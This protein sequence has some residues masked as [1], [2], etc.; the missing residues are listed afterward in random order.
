[1]GGGQRVQPDIHAGQLQAGDRVLDF[2][3]YGVD[4]G[5]E[6]LAML[7]RPADAQRLGGKAHVHDRGRVALGRSQVDQP[8]LAQQVDASFLGQMI[9]VEV[10][11]QVLFNL[12]GHFG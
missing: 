5:V 9:T 12:F 1:M 8:S 4:A 10:G 7:D 6:I 11:A 3:R 2:L